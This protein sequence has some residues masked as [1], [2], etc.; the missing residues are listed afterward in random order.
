M[1]Y[2]S[3][4]E[5]ERDR[6][7]TISDATRHVRRVEDCDEAEALRQL[8][9]ALENRA[10]FAKWDEPPSVTGPN[11]WGQFDESPEYSP[12]WFGPQ[13]RGDEVLDDAGATEEGRAPK[14]RRWRTLLILKHD[15][16]RLWP[17][18]PKKP[19]RTTAASETACRTWLETEMGKSPE[20]PT[21]PKATLLGR[22]REKWPSL[23]EQ[24]FNRAWSAAATSVNAPAWSR[25]GR[26]P[27]PPN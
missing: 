6:W 13:R 26:R 1:P 18:G 8:S 14:R 23:G 17:P 3:P 20:R 15:V 11:V 19:D 21:G 22:A 2:R 10:L 7:Q 27:K 12:S 16:A 24:A 5:I 9:A 25:G 4:T